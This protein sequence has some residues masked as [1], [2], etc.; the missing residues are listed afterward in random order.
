[1]SRPGK[2]IVSAMRL[3]LAMK[4]VVAIHLGLG[5]YLGH[6]LFAKYHGFD[7]EVGLAMVHLLRTVP[8]ALNVPQARHG[9]RDRR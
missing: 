8:R 2:I 1:M 9:F 7:V 5:M 6:I 3:G 4:V